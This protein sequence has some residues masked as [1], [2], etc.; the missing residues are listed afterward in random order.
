MKEILKAKMHVDKLMTIYKKKSNSATK[1]DD[2]SALLKHIRLRKMKEIH[3][4]KRL[5]DSIQLTEEDRMQRNDIRTLKRNEILI[6]LS[7]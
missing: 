3:L 6:L 1:Q 5:A 4:V 2:C 7:I